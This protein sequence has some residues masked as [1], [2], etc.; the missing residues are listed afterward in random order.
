MKRIYLAMIFLVIALPA[1]AEPA[2]I[3]IGLG[4]VHAAGLDD[5][6]HGF[7]F[8]NGFGQPGRSYDDSAAGANLYGGENIGDFF[9]VEGGLMYLGS[10][11]LRGNF[12]SGGARINGRATD[13]VSAVYGA[14]LLQ[15]WLTPFLGGFLKVGVAGTMDHESCRARGAICRSSTSSGASPLFGAGLT[16]DTSPNFGFRLEFSQINDVGN[17]GQFTHGDFQAVEVSIFGLI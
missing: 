5:R 4:G 17:R 3:G 1:A 15:G 2:Y 7:Q 14:G 13:T 12:F 6:H 11:D 10:Y 9:A 8:T 16:I